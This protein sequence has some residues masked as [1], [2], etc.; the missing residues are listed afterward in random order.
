VVAALAQTVA[1]ARAEL[2]R[3]LAVQ[4]AYLVVL[5]GLVAAAVAVRSRGLWVFAAAVTAGEVLRQAG[6]VRLLRRVAGLS[7]AQVWQAYAPAAFAAAGVALAVAMP[8][9]ALSGRAPAPVTLAFELAAGALGLALCIRFGPLAA[10]RRELA[11]RLEEAG[12]LGR[13]G[14]LRRRLAPLVLGRPAVPA[15][16]EPR[17]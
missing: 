6:Y 5:G 12:V 2:N 10:L 14:G 16:P 4:A 13:A 7:A 1:E 8:R 9:A 3:S 17:P 11:M 15:G